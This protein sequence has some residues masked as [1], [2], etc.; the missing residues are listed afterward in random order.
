M[1]DEK[2]TTFRGFPPYFSV[3][4]D[5]F[6]SPLD[7][8]VFLLCQEMKRARRFRAYSRTLSPS[9]VCVAA[10][11]QCLPAVPGEKNLSGSAVPGSA[12]P[13]SDS[14]SRANFSSSFHLVLCMAFRGFPPGLSVVW[15]MCACD[16]FLVSQYLAA[17]PTAKRIEKGPSRRT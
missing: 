4:L 8:L 6:G 12:V 16:L 3:V 10:G 5:G 14:S 1:H 17:L 13:D 11:P 15:I 2:S 7:H 9:R